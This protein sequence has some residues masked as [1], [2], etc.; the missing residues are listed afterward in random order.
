M[1]IK[2]LRIKPETLKLI[3]EKIGNSLEDMSTGE[4]S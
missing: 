1:W 4:N 3:K 2:E